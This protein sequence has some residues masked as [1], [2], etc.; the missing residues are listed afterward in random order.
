M[1][2]AKTGTPKALLATHL[3]LLPVEEIHPG[4]SSE[5]LL[6]CEHAGQAIPKRLGTLGLSQGQRGL[7]IA[8]DIG[9]EKVA[10]RLAQRQGSILIM[11]RY[12]RLVIDCNRPLGSVQSIPEFS[13]AMLIPGNANLSDVER[14]QREI[15]I[16]E[17]FAERCRNRIASPHIRFAFS[18]HSFTPEMS[19]QLRPWD[20]GLLY[21]S[22]DSHGDRLAAIAQEMWPDMLVG[23]NQPY[24]IED[25]T[26]WFIPVCAEPKGIPHCL[27][28]IRNDHL[29]TERGCLDWADRLHRL[30]W[31]FMEATD[32]IDP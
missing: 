28:E 20:L 9:A 27:I 4:A 19:G 3:D 13:D 10:R 30:L 15:S 1:T 31:A 2:E 32:D 24:Q 8:Y 18:I 25:E 7:H 22:P 23:C 11:Q 29:S 12:S 26:D 16:F 5:V 14:K 17:P 21:R 6:I